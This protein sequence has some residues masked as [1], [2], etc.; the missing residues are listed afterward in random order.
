MNCFAG[1]SDI[2]RIKGSATGARPRSAMRPQR[3]HS[4]YLA[5]AENIPNGNEKADTYS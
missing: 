4:L 5:D 3:R 1:L 2:D